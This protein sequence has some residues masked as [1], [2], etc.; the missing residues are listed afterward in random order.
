MDFSAWFEAYLD[1]RWLTFDACHNRPRIGRVLMA[2]GRAA[3]D[4]AFLTS[5]GTATMTK[6]E[7]TADEVPDGAHVRRGEN[8]RPSFLAPLARKEGPP[9]DRVR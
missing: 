1:G 5:F 4:V 6:F 2:A 7:V 3:A 8:T 9:R